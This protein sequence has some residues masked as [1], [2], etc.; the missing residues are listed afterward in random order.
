ML[1]LRATGI[2]LTMM[3]LTT[4]NNP[5]HPPDQEK[6]QKDQKL[7]EALI[8][9]NKRAVSEEKYMIRRYIK[10]HKWDMKK[11]GFGIYYGVY[12]EGEGIQARKGMRATLDY[13]IQLLNGYVCYS[14]KEKGSPK[15][16]II[17]KEGDIVSGL[18][19]IMP[20]LQKGDKAKII[21]PSYLAHGIAGDKREV[22]SS[23][24]L[25]Y[26]IHVLKLERP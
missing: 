3:L 20:H 7:E 2:L 17:G 4:C 19:K 16:F 10:R 6:Q 15:K 23:A 22:P 24:T 5:P 14:S 9:A 1:T 18:H 13:T 25:V 21:I 12:Q 11:T 26:D 8:E